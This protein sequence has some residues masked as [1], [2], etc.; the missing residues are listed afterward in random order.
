MNDTATETLAKATELLAQAATRTDV[1][2]LRARYLG[3]KGEVA[4]LM[5]KIPELPAEAR[6][7]AGRAANELKRSLSEVV[8]AARAR[9]ARQQEEAVAPADPT[10]P[11]IRPP[12]GH[13]HPVSQT[14][15]ETADIFRGLGFEV[16]EGP[17][18][19][20]DWYNFEALNVPPDHPSRDDWDTFYVTDNVLLRPQTSPAQIRVMQ[21]TPPPLRIIAP[22]RCFRRDTEDATHFSMFH[23]V[24]GL[25]VDEGVSFGDL[26]A[27]LHA[28]LRQLF[29]ADVDIRFQPDFF[30]FTEPSAQLHCTCV[31]CG[32]EGCRTCSYTGWLELLGCG[33][34]DPNVFEAVGYDAERY[35]GWAFGV[36]VERLAML[37]YQIPDGRMFYQGDVRFLRQF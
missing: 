20:L 4:E 31:I 5:A 18:V 36:G 32:G 11:G 15:E 24:E 25:M 1:E 2:A 22:G 30:P 9:I 28:F 10:L 35:T 29:R 21:N 33:M 13:I 19:E 17:E 12:L 34:V 26:K 23:Q 37:K 16:V 6:P 14:I 27:V 3:R 7:A 8:E